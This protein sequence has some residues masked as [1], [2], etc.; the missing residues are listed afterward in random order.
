MSLT[1]ITLTL[2]NF[3]DNLQKILEYIDLI[4]NRWRIGT[5]IGAIGIW[6]YHGCSSTYIP[7]V[8][9]ICTHSIFN[10]KSWIYTNVL[11]K[12][13]PTRN[14]KNTGY[15]H[16]IGNGIFMAIDYSVIK[17][18]S[19]S[20]VPAL[21][22]Y[23]IPYRYFSFICRSV[24]VLAI[25][26]LYIPQVQKYIIRR[27]ANYFRKYPLI[28]NMIYIYS[29]L[30][31]NNTD[32]N[33]TYLK[34]ANQIDDSIAVNNELTCGICMQEAH[35]IINNDNTHL[36]TLRKCGHVFCITCIESLINI[37]DNSNFYYNLNKK[38]CPM[39]RIII[40]EYND[41]LEDH[42]RH[43]FANIQF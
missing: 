36:T 22:K 38:L 3:S 5:G 16:M 24:S 37:S 32:T 18:L 34:V 20:F 6:C 10:Y 33:L 11:Y 15:M 19:P 30:S 40:L 29:D 35:T 31:Q 21:H 23:I 12:I 43:I 42:I 13:F 2:Q 28:T 26:S 17:W 39:C 1:S 4:E 8:A 25:G 41:Y 9:V 7:S 14:L 27:I